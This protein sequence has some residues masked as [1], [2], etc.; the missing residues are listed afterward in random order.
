MAN[1]AVRKRLSYY[2]GT[3]ASQEALRAHWVDFTWQTGPVIVASEGPWGCAKVWAAS[4]AE[5]KRVIRHAGAQGGWDPDDPAV[6][7]WIVTSSADS[8]FGR[9]ALVRVKVRRGVPQ[10]SKRDGPSGAPPA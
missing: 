1:R 6:G 4:E 9:E 3:G 10:I 8:R 7:R 5:G 2:D